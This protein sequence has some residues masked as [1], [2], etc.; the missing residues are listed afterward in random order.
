[1]VRE[2]YFREQKPDFSGWAH[3]GPPFLKQIWSFETVRDLES[4]DFMD[5][6]DP[7]FDKGKFFR[8]Y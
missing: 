8:L 6:T 4:M 5:L 3:R 7:I 2:A 1:V